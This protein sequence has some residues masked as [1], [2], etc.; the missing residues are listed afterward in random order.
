MCGTSKEYI[1]SAAANKTLLLASKGKISKKCFLPQK[2]TFFTSFHIFFTHFSIV[3]GMN[4]PADDTRHNR[5][6]EKEGKTGYEDKCA[7]TI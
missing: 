1:H 6:S 4:V 2:P 7:K 5:R 3:W